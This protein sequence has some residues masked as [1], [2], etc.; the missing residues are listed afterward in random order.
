MSVLAE[1][2]YDVAG[3]LDDL[4]GPDLGTFA[5]PDATPPTN[6]CR[7]P[8]TRSAPCWWRLLRLRDVEERLHAELREARDERDRARTTPTYRARGG[9][10]SPLS[11]T[12]PTGRGTLD[13]YRRVRGR[14]S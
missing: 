11:R 9:R 3:S 1:R 14:K 10:S 7:R 6:C 2:G 12:P 5:D 8:S 13:A 4:L